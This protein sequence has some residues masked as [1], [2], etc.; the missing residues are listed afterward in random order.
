MADLAVLGVQHLVLCAEDRDELAGVLRH[1]YPQAVS[2]ANVL[3]NLDAA[4]AHPEAAG[5][6]H[7]SDPDYIVPNGGMS[8]QEARA[9]FSMWT[10]L[11]A[12]MMLSVDPTKLSRQLL[13]IVENPDAIA[14]S[15]DPSG[16]QGVKV[17][18]SAGAEVWVK[19]LSNGQ[20]AVALLNRTQS[21]VKATVRAAVIGLGSASR[22]GVKDIWAHS[23]TVNG[24][25]FT[26]NVPAHSAILLCIGRVS[27]QTHRRQPSVKGRGLASRRRQVRCM[28]T[29]E[30][31][32]TS[33]VPE[34]TSRSRCSTRIRSN[35]ISGFRRVPSATQ[36][37][38]TAA[39]W[40]PVTIA[41]Q[42]GG[43]LNVDEI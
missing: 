36:S 20:R 35:S 2:F 33:S 24:P 9:Q 4:A 40:R 3:H 34:T 38:F 18:Q 23:T 11:T 29:G 1:R 21:P 43:R 10:V 14:I 6:G 7:F 27:A 17:A 15:Q 41:H 22:L 28:I 13:A 37:Q 8:Y 31:V 30:P 42:D 25:A 5:N 16:V 12:P 32:A 26:E 19:P 39:G